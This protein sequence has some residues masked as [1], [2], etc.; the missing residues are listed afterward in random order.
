[1]NGGV[2]LCGVAPGKHNYEGTSKRRRAVGDTVSDLTNPG[3]E[4]QT[5]SIDSS[6]LT[7][8]TSRFTK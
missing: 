3:F 6:V 5:S 7:E 8:L 4:P 1:M 2:H